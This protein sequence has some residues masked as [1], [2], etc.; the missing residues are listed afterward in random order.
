GSD[1]HAVQGKSGSNQVSRAEC[2]RWGL[3]QYAEPS[4]RTRAIAYTAG[5]LG[6]GAWFRKH[7]RVLCT[8]EKQRSREE[9]RMADFRREV[10]ATDRVR[11]HNRGESGAFVLVSHRRV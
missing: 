2:R 1:V 10:R 8:N 3:L 7:R 11:V 9:F 5:R 4:R 6:H